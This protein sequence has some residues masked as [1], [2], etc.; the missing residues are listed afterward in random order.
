MIYFISVEGWNNVKIG[1][2]ANIAGRLAQLQSASSRKL[3]VIRELPGERWVEKWMHARFH[4]LRL[5]GEW[6]VFDSEMMSIEPPSI[7][8]VGL[9]KNKWLPD[10]PFNLSIKLPWHALNEIG[11]DAA[12]QGV[13]LQEWHRDAALT[14]LA[15]NKDAPSIAAE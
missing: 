9:S 5:E 6:F 3:T 14:Y 7:K 12:R 2:S 13:T 1:W 8:P 4:G 15:A 10:H 11:V